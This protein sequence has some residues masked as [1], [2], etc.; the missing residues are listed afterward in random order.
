L[1]CL[2]HLDHLPLTLAFCIQGVQ[3]VQGDHA[4]GLMCFVCLWVGSTSTRRAH[5][6]FV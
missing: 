4:R 6:A 5:L 2:D 3:G 1:D